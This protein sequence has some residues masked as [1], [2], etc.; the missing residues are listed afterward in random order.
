MQPA[1]STSTA[2]QTRLRRRIVPAFTIDLPKACP[3]RII[4]RGLIARTLAAHE[5]RSVATRDARGRKAS[6]DDT[7]VF[8]TGVGDSGCCD[9]NEYLRELDMLDETLHQCARQDR[10]LVYFSSAGRIYGDVAAPRDEMTP[11]VPNSEYGRHKLECETLIRRFP[12]RHLIVRLAN[13][14]GP[15]QNSQQL[16]PQLVAQILAG[17]VSVFREATR[18][19]LGVDRFAEMLAEVLQHAPPRETLVMATGI[20]LP[21]REIVQLIGNALQVPTAVRL[22]EKGDRQEFDI[23]RL[24]ALAP[25]TSR[26]DRNYPA[27]I[28]RQYG[29]VTRLTRN[30]V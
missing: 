6:P 1:D 4:G 10:R 7:V 21:V 18:D 19:L 28:L 26:F 9:P 16:I 2:E 24:R 3:V 15:Q 17:E 30:P 13:L 14:V 5:A 25:T 12:G 22:I 29:L 27:R 20:S 23:A 8:A 11:A